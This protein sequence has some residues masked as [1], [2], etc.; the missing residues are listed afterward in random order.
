[1]L[2]LEK[3]VTTVTRYIRNLR[4]GSQPILAEASDGL[5]YV[6][7]FTNNL[8]G[9]NLP[10]NESIGSE[11]Y[12]ICGL[13]VPSWKPLLVS[14]T[15]IDQN[16]DCWMQTSEGKL[17][18]D[19]G[20]CFGSR[21]LGEDSKRLLEILPEN[22]FKRIH[23]RESFWLAW[24]IDICASHVDNRQAVFLE[25]GEGQLNAFFVDHGHLFGGPKGGQRRHFQVSC[26]LDPR[27]YQNIC[28]Q[29]HL[30]F[31]KIVQSIDVEQSWRWIKTLPADWKTPSALDSFS[32]CLKN[33]STPTLVQNILDAMVEALQRTDKVRYGKQQNG[34]FSPKP[35]LRSGIQAKELEHRLTRRSGGFIACAPR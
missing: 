3:K 20:L 22:S 4:G 28:S 1:M 34:R 30:N 35:V 9:P 7:K 14:D 18:P 32:Q 25:D 2:A 24:L 12:R 11:L 16:K 33:L 21:F 26:Y 5:L 23:N 19:S 13:T 6:V 29:Q 15:F 10:F 31:R 27:I 17:R 8:Q